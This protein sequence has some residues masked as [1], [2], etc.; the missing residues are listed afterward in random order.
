MYLF[1]V[2]LNFRLQIDPI[3][4]YRVKIG[5]LLS[6]IAAATSFLLLTLIVQGLRAL[7]N[8]LVTLNQKSKQS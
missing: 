3:V 7:F 5:S 1:F 8:K 4:F 6:G 2:S